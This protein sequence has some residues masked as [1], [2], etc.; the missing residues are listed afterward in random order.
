MSATKQDLM[1]VMINH[2]GNKRGISASQLAIELDVNERRIRHLI[3]EL[4]EDGIAICGHPATGYYVAQTTEDL[5]Q[6]L[7][8]LKDR[9]IHSL[10]LHSKLS[11]EPLADLIGQLHLRT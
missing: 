7:D 9:A 8:F 10:R 1:A 4:R 11:G 2:C 6:T 3:T 5:K